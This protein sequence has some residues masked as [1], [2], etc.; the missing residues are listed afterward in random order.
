M[1][2]ALLQCD[3]SSPGLV[4]YCP[5]TIKIGAIDGEFGPSKMVSGFHPKIPNIFTFVRL[6]NYYD[7]LFLSLGGIAL[8]YNYNSNLNVKIQHKYTSTQLAHNVL[9][10]MLININI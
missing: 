1:E 10:N 4:S 6:D 3:D 9:I 7:D 2:Y 5:F 8:F